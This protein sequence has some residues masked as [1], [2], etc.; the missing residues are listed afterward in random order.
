MAT[1]G[2]DFGTSV[3]VVAA[4]QKG[5]IDVLMNETSSRQTPAVVGFGDKQ[6]YVGEAAAVQQLTNM[7]NTVGQIKRLLGRKWDADLQAELPMLG[8]PPVVPL[9]DDKIGLEVMYRGEKVVFLPEQLAAMMLVQLRGLAEKGTGAK[10][11]EVVVSVPGY[12][13]DLQRRAMLDSCQIAG[14]NCMRII[15]DMTACALSYGIY[16]T[17]IPDNEPL[18]V[19]FVDVGYANTNVAAVEFHKDKFKI[20][21][22]SFNRNMGGRNIDWV[23]ANF[24]A[25]AFQAKHKTDPR[26]NPR[27]WKRILA[28]AEK[29]K[30]TLN[31]NPTAAVN[32]EC[33]I[34]EI[35][36]NMLMKREEFMELIEKSDVLPGILQ[37]IKEVLEESGIATDKFNAIEI[38]GGSSRAQVVQNALK[39]F[40]NRELSQTTNAEENIAKGAAL[41][42]AVLSPKFRVRDYTIIDGTQYSVTVAW[43]SHDNANDTQEKSVELFKKYNPMPA[44]KHVTFPRKDTA[45]F[46]VDARYTDPTK[47]PPGTPQ[48]LASYL[49]KNI[50]NPQV[51]GGKIE[52][53]LKVRLDLNGL[54]TAESPE[55]VEDIEEMVPEEVP[56]TPETTATDGDAAMKD[57]AEKK[58]PKMVK[59][60][61]TRYT[62][63]KLETLKSFGLSPGEIQKSIKVEGDMHKID[64]EVIATNDA[65]N[66]VEAYVY[67]TKDKL[68]GSWEKFIAPNDKDTFYSQLSATEDWLYEEEQTKQVYEKKLS[69]LKAIGDK[70]AVRFNESE[71]RPPALNEFWQTIGEYKGKAA[72]TDPAYDHIESADREKLLAECERVS[73]LIKEHADKQA[74]LQAHQD[75]VLLTKDLKERTNNLRIFGN[76]IMNK[77][78]PKPKETPKEAPK[79]GEAATNAAQPEQTQANPENAGEATSN[80]AAAPGSEK[81]EVD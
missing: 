24:I 15:N 22:Q 12:W 76:G 78:K 71:T 79:E 31:M 54:V 13:T 16:K 34:G 63:C 77:P 28:N 10:V 5:G 40:F 43:K 30:K 21:S 72:S 61:V 62:P 50:P 25:D 73:S 68:N 59:K 2:F 32:I 23:L 1:V 37:P 80:N 51:A 49:I 66:A 44:P 75:P 42:C 18:K 3:C 67:D 27:A 57:T 60:V 47:L 65:R 45:P 9:P 52:V 14:L 74:T 70:V 58:E 81:M 20:L 35:D 38:L 8:N 17:N 53:R 56:K 29:V 64:M 26:T 4:A 46:Q 11:S 41:Q 19:L 33:L 6:R 36:F 55:L 48:C 69:E 7:K 39:T